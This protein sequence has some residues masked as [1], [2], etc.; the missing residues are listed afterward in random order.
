MSADLSTNTTATRSSGDS[1]HIGRRRA[2]SLDAELQSLDGVSLRELDRAQL[3][4]RV[5]TK[6]LARAE[7]I[8]DVLRRLASDYVVMDHEASRIQRYSNTYFD[9]IDLQS[10]T[11]HH[12]QKRRRS[13]IRYRSYVNSGLTY[14]E[15]KRHV[16]GRTVKERKVS[17]PVDGSVRADDR[18]FLTDRL[19]VDPSQLGASVVIDYDRILL[20][21]RDFQE[22]VT[23]DTSVRVRT[24]RAVAEFRGLAVV[25]FKQPRLDRHS[26][27]IRAIPRPTQMFS[28]YCMG[29]ATCDPTL[30]RNRFKKVFLGLERLDV[31]PELF[32]AEVS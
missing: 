11:E 30:K 28:K 2:A 8:P 21:R 24:S 29:L 32:R 3:H 23:I 4:D 15:I 10:Y 27:A 31:L 14:F 16:D 25:E 7:V 22:R 5:E 13:K 6:L 9:T 20:V 26:P 18:P 12:N 17:A 19:P 1:C